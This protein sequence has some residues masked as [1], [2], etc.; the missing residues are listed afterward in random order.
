VNWDIKEV[1]HM[2]PKENKGN[3]KQKS[4][5]KYRHCVM[6]TWTIQ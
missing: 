4:E 5:N 3:K 6:T 2:P 1:K